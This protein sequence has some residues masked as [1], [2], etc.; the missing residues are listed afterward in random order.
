[1]ALGAAGCLSA[2]PNLAPELCA[3]IANGFDAGDMGR[4]GRAQADLD[5]PRHAGQQVG[6]VNGALGEDGHEGARPGQWRAAPAVL[7]PGQDQQDEMLAGLR[8]LG[9][10]PKA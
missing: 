1:M 5:P 9:I 7:L 6:A 4:A 3:E 8:R 2:E 10:H